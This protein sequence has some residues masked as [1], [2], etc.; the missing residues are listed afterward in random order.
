MSY[1]FSS[2]AV[3][4]G[5]PDKLCDQISDALLD[6]V[7]LHDS[8][9][10]VALETVASGK[11]IH[12]LGEM[13]SSFSLTPELVADTVHQKIASIGYTPASYGYNFCD[14][15]QVLINCQISE[16][17]PDIAQAVDNSYELK[18]GYAADKYDL[19]GAGDQGII[20]GFASDELQA[21]NTTAAAAECLPESNFTSSNNSI[22][23]PI[24]HQQ[25]KSFMPAAI[26]LAQQLVKR[27]GQLQLKNK[28]IFGPDAKAQVTLRYAA[29]G[30]PLAVDT[31]LISAQHAAD[32]N[33]ETLQ[34]FLSSEVVFPILERAGIPYDKVK[35]LLNPSGKFIIGG[36]QADAGLT[37]RKIVVDTY[38]GYAPHGG[39]A[40]SGKD[41]SKVDR[42]AAYAAR[43]V[44]KNLVANGLARW[45][46]VQLAYAIG[47]AHPVS[48]H[49]TSDNPAVDRQLQQ[50]VTARF[51][52]RPAAIIE[53][54]GLKHF[55]EYQKTAVFGHF[56]RDDLD[57]PW[58]DIIEL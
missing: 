31:V 23:S 8:E 17:S 40:F 3:A 56:G 22:D 57:L 25:H 5:H 34:E 32:I 14:S 19:L 44:A 11:Q 41:P 15:S 47:S 20:F 33:Q 1:L 30:V 7:L 24:T 16:Q 53:R 13:R 49:I 39:G 55:T 42:S 21:T 12:V 4:A 52:L 27:Y 6:L 26:W 48:I 58:E 35:L 43:W 28:N 46:T 29:P 51:D 18:L 9:A 38:G 37:G 50:L 2:E 10:K 36:P 54:L 45:V